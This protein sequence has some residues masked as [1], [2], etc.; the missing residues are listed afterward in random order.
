MM[1]P[2][3]DLSSVVISLLF[4]I[5]LLL[6][7]T[8]MLHLT[9]SEPL[10][11]RTRTMQKS[12]SESSVTEQEELV[13]LLSLLEKRPRVLLTVLTKTILLLM[14]FRLRRCLCSLMGCICGQVQTSQLLVLRTFRWCRLY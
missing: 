3:L 10:T 8:L 14:V 2:N 11:I 9:G 5:S 6:A 7:T 13:E 12:G 1:G 4:R